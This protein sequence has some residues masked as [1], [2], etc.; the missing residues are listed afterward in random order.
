MRLVDPD[1]RP[2]DLPP[3]RVN[4]VTMAFVGTVL[5]VLGTVAAGFAQARG[6]DLP[7]GWL[8][9]C[10]VGIG[11]GGVMLVWGGFHEWRAERHG[12]R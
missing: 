11:L 7:D 4:A 10:L 8:R 12:R 1:E 5:W 2:A 6:M 3:Q 9:V